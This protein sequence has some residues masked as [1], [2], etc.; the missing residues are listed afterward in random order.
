MAG[1]SDQRDESSSSESLTAD[2]GGRNSTEE[3]RPSVSDQG[4][5]DDIPPSDTLRRAPHIVFLTLCYAAI[6]VYAWV[7]LCILSY[8]PIGAPSYTFKSNETFSYID[9]PGVFARSERYLRAVRFLQSV[10][11]VL[12]IPLTSMVCSYAAVVFLQRVRQGGPTLRQSM[13]LADKG[14][15]D[16]ALIAKLVVG[17]WKRYGSAFLLAAICLNI[18]DEQHPRPPRA[19]TGLNSSSRSVFPLTD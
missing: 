10:V 1:R 2:E 8:K 17:G 16:P 12:T 7:V 18:I 13:M 15:S 3:A 9:S 19:S 14:W 6:S 11:S 5:S 4:K